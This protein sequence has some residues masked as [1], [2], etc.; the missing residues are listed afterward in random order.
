MPH[1]DYNDPEVEFPRLEARIQKI[2]EESYWLTIWLWESVGI[3]REKT[4]FN[5]KQAGS[6][7][8]AQQIIDEASTHFQAHVNEG[9]IGVGDIPEPDR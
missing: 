2:D 6:W 9:D 3:R 8:D 1:T 5:R 4:V 7:K